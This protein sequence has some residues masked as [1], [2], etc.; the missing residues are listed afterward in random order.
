MSIQLRL[1]V[2]LRESRRD[3][4]ER[5]AALR[6]EKRSAR[7][8]IRAILDRLAD[9]YGIPDKDIE[10]S[11]EGY[12]DNL[13]GDAVYNLETELEREVEEQDPV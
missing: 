1:P 3:P 2:V 11:M 7:M 5:L 8:E 6:R 10:Y 9:R 4:R 12:A 13:L